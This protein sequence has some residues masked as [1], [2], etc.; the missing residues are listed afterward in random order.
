[1]EGTLTALAPAYR[2]IWR[3]LRRLVLMRDRREW[4]PY[5]RT[6]GFGEREVYARCLGSVFELLAGKCCGERRLCGREERQYY[7]AEAR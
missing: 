4:R 5:A 7:V 6:G 1:M 3:S 2:S